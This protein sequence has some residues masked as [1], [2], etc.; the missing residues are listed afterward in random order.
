MQ[1]KN[2]LKPVIPHFIAIAIFLVISV[3]YFYPVLEGKV[4]HTNDGTVAQNSAKEISDFRAK[5]GEEPL[6]TNSMFSGMPAYL[7]SVRFSGNIMQ[8]AHKI[9]TILKLPIASIFLSMLGFYILLLIFKVDWRL[10]IAGAIAYGFSTYFF[11]ILA[12]GHN[13]KAIAIAYM[14]PMIGGIYYT[15]RNHA[16][17]G[18]LITTFFL[19]LEIIANHPQITYY[20]L[21]CIMVFIIGEFIYSVRK[22]E[23][24]KFIKNSVILI[25]PVLL[26][27]GMNFNSLYTTYEYSKYSTRSKS[28]LVT[29][30][31]V[32]TSGL[33]KDY[34]TQWSYGIDETLTLLIPDFRGGACQPFD[35]D[36]E[37]VKAL[38][39]NNAGQYVNSFVRYWGSQPWVDGPVYVGAIIFFLF[40]LGL[41]IVKGAEKWWLLSATILSVMLAWGKNFMPFTDLFL[42]YFPGYNKF[43]AVTMILVIA[44]FCIPL[45]GILALRNIFDES[46][47]KK[48][49]LKGI[50][51][52]FGITGGLTLLLVF[53]PGLAGSF[54][55]P[56]EQQQQIPSWLSSALVSDR[57][58]LLR[59]DALR[60]F[61]FILL[62][63][64]AILGFYYQKIKKGH[65]VVFLAILF[66]ADMWFVDKR[67]LNADRFVRKEAKVKLSSPSVA[68]NII[69]KDVS[70]YRVLNLAVSPFNDASTSLYHK[71]IG[72]YHGAKLKRYQELI[73]SSLVNDISMI[74]KVGTYAKT[75][76]DLQSVF[77]NT[78]A[79]NMLN[80]KYVIYNPDAAPLVNPDALG[81]AWFVETPVMVNN[82]NEELSTVNKIDP[83]FQAVIDNRFKDQV[84]KTEYPKTDGDMIE[85]KSYKANELVY[86]SSAQ[87]EKLAVFSE[88]YYPAG[89]KC[90]IDGKESS[91][92]RTDWVLRGMVVPAGNHEIKFTFKPSSYMIG[93]KVS[94]A[95]SILFILLIAGYFIAEL[96]IKPKF[97]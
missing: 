57:K 86:T 16:I 38:R 59:S 23:I 32:Q 1:I 46:S 78:P 24:S 85:L 9:L 7:I 87:G 84:R 39:K 69:L 22:Q 30:G 10:A 89:W 70:D 44:E 51:I 62:G 2:R 71:S 33:D 12:A 42:N 6:W 66:L 27:V 41:I 97:E 14:A 35:K 36:S 20:S 52:A 49:I 11:F 21:I 8:F 77:N 17:R 72:G 81:N 48:D 61:V 73:D 28:E 54:I 65:A 13:T 60:S 4:L 26:S 88:I 45:L 15:Y 74:Q 76:E 83:A 50:K 67:Y 18:A 3:V 90:F 94:L 25:I 64:I 80:T 29:N 79:L 43:R 75:I 95:S 34:I 58:D 55:S 37:T 68:D 56:V 82:A 93:N 91:Y 47:P 63:T 96:K 92:F 40:I 19:T 5:Y 53:F 31:T